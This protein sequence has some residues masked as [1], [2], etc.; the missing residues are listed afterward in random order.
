LLVLSLLGFLTVVNTSFPS[1]PQ[2][3]LLV[4]VS[5]L[6][7]LL[8]RILDLPSLRDLGLDCHNALLHFR[9]SHLKILDFSTRSFREAHFPHWL[10]IDVDAGLI[11]SSET[12]L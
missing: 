11:S 10:F 2:K 1:P 9:L 7:L 5:W 3:P 12:V 4:V 8:V 6:L